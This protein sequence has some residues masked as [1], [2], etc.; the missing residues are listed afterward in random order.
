MDLLF[1]EKAIYHNI[2]IKVKKFIKSQNGKLSEKPTAL[3]LTI[4]K[5]PIIA[6]IA[7]MNAILPASRFYIICQQ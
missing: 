1:K 7:L 3:V 6:D 2:K 5:N 4:V